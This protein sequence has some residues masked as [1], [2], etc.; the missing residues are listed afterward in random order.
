MGTTKG[1]PTPSGGEW[2]PLKN[3]ITDNLSGDNKATPDRIVGGTVRALGGLGF[4]SSA[5]RSTGGGGGSGGDGG[6]GG[7]GRGSGGRA[8]LGGVTS[9]LGGFGGAFQHGG[10]DEA[11]GSLGLGDLKGKPASEVISRIA[12]HLAESDDPLQRD[13]LCDALKDTLIEVAALEE[14][15]E[16]SDLEAALQAFFDQ[17]G[18]EGLVQSFLTNYVFDRVWNAVESHAEFK[19][20]GTGAEALGIAVGQACRSH[21]ESLISESKVAGRFDKTDWFGQGGIKLGNELVA[22]L[23]GRLKAL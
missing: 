22:E 9:R 18:V 2:T 7:G 23:E 19:A 17:N 13:I 8:S 21:V 3:D 11:L 10:L 12:E 4:P 14:G 1:K 20:Q 15:G 16:Y 6:G 5:T